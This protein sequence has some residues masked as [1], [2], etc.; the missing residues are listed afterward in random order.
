M[1]LVLSLLHRFQTLLMKHC[2][3]YILFALSIL[4]SCQK[5]VHKSQSN[6]QYPL[7]SETYSE[8]WKEVT[9][10]EKKGAGK[11]IIQKTGEILKKAKQD[12]NYHQVFKA[13]SY[14]SRYINQIEE[15]AHLKILTDFEKELN[16]AHFPLNLLLHSAIAELYSQYLSVNQWRYQNRTSIS[17]DRTE[18][19]R[20][21]SLDKIHRTINTHYK[22]S[23][24]LSEEASQFPISHLKP[25]LTETSDST[26]PTIYNSLYDFLAYRALNHFKA[27]PIVDLGISS[28]N[29]DDYYPF[30]TRKEFSQHN[31]QY[32]DS[33]DLQYLSFKL[34]QN[35]L[36][37]LQ[38]EPLKKQISFDLERLSHYHVTSNLPKKD[39]LFEA[40]LLHLKSEAEDNYEIRF[41]L[42][43]FYYEKGMEY[44]AHS[45]D[46]AKRWMTKKA[47]D[48]ISDLP[49]D[50]NDY[51]LAKCFDLLKEIEQESISFEMENIHV[52]NK[53][54]LLKLHFRNANEF[55]F[56]I[57]E[58][59]K[60]YEFKNKRHINHDNFMKQLCKMPALETWSKKVNL[61][62]DYQ[63]HSTELL[64][65]KLNIGKYYL[66]VSTQSNFNLTNGHLAYQEFQ[67]SQLSKLDRRRNNQIELYILDRES[68]KGMEGIQVDFYITK[69]QPNRSVELVSSHKSDK[70][71]F[72]SM[73]T[74]KHQRYSYKIYSGKDTLHSRHFYH[75]NDLKHQSRK[76]MHFFTDRAIYRPG[77][78]V[79]F[80]ALLYNSKGNE[81]KP[82]EKENV[83]I[84]LYDANGQ[85][86]DTIQLQSNTYGSVKGTFILPASG[87]NG[88]Y[89]IQGPSGSIQFAVEEYKRPTFKVSLDSLDGEARLNQNIHL[90]GSAKGFAGNPITQAKV[91]YRVIRKTEF[92]FKR[93]FYWD[94]YIPYHISQKEIAQGQ[95]ETGSDGIYQIEFNAL[96][97]NLNSSYQAI[98]N[99]QIIIDVIAINGET[100]S[101]MHNVRI[102]QRP[103]YISTNLK[104]GEVNIEDLRNL[105]INCKN[106]QGKRIDKKGSL[107]LVRLKDKSWATK[108]RFWQKPDI[109]SLDEVTYRSLRVSGRNEEVI[110]DYQINTT[111]FTAN[112]PLHLY[113]D[114]K[115]GQYELRISI[116]DQNGESIYYNEYFILNDFHSSQLPVKQFESIKALTTEGDPG[117]PARFLI[118]S[119]LV[120]LNVLYELEHG[121]KIIRQKWLKINDQQQLI[122]IP[123][124]EE[125]RGGFSVHFNAVHSNRSLHYLYDITVPF[126]NKNL[127]IK[128]LSHRDKLNPG[129][130]E[131]WSIKVEKN[132][133]STKESEVLVS[134]YDASLD[135]FRSQDWEWFPYQ[136]YK[137][138]LAWH[139]GTFGSIFSNEYGK[140]L[141]TKS[142]HR[143]VPQLNWFGFYL[144][145]GYRYFAKSNFAEPLML[146]DAVAVEDNESM[147][148]ANK[149]ESD[150]LADVAGVRKVNTV[151]N[152]TRKNFNETAFFY[153]Q[154]KT[155]NG[156]LNFEFKLPDALT[157]WKFRAFAHDQNFALGSFSK[158][159]VSQKEIMLFPNAPRF[160]REGDQ[161]LF[162]SSISN[163][164]DQWVEVMVRLEF[165]NPLTGRAIDL[166][167]DSSPTQR[168]QIKAKGN[169]SVDWKIKI[170]KGIEAIAYKISAES[171]NHIDSEERAIPVLP[172]RT[173][174][175]E[176]FPLSLRGKEIKEWKWEAL[177][178]AGNKQN[179]EHKSLS[180]EFSPNPVWY[181]IQALPYM[182]EQNGECTEQIFT[183]FFA[184]SIA[185]FIIQDQP[186]IKDI[187][188]QWEVNHS[189][190]LQSNLEKHQDLKAILIEETPWLQ[191]AKS[192]TEQ[193]KR[194]TLLFD[195][196][197][198]AMQKNNSLQKLKELQLSNGA[199]A[200]YTGMRPN[201]YLTQYLVSGFG[202]LHHLRIND[203]P[204]MIKNAIHYLDQEMIKDYQKLKERK[205][206]LKLNHLGYIHIYY[207]YARSFFPEVPLPSDRTAFDYYLNQ[208]QSYWTEQSNYM[209]GLI[210]LALHRSHPELST[211]KD[212]LFSLTDHA[213]L[214]EEMGMYWK[215][216]KGGYYWYNA[217]IE[218]HALLIEAFEEIGNDLS[219]IDELKIWLL[220][221]KQTQA[222]PSTRST[223]LACYALLQRGSNL[224]QQNEETH[225]QIGNQI[226]SSAEIQQEAG[227]GYFIKKWSA[228]EIDSNMGEIAAEN[229]NESIAW[230]ALHWQYYQN[231]DEVEAAGNS[232][233]KLHKQVFKVDLNSK[234]E[235]LTP[236]E[237]TP[238]QKGDKLRVRLKIE[239]DR[240]LE[241][242][243]LKDL[244]ASGLEPAQTLSGYQFQDGLGY[245]LSH[246]DA[247]TN[248]F[249]DYLKRGT[250]VLEYTLKANISGDFSNG[251]ST[252]QCFYAP[253]FN[254][255]SQGERLQID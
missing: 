254:S 154:Q 75:S 2:L 51:A 107:E 9:S 110:E 76:N 253:E 34:Y 146:L 231:L 102:S 47:H 195:Y 241:F 153:P 220:K 62:R 189:G 151:E 72:V 171:E 142:F 115:P 181:A 223:A 140:K 117:D 98:Y 172:N 158:T 208:A 190:A 49:Y 185:E 248:F 194:I 24:N 135:Q 78:H 124:K 131:K 251:F 101:L 57:L 67:V 41:E 138:R 4:L 133:E 210:A 184:N 150:D 137:S 228:S 44:Q 59:S 91:N 42:A 43:R 147:V 22:Q 216:N 96:A 10:L 217:K 81:F 113:K 74:E 7:I 19:I 30:S 156:E 100:Q 200:W 232:G 224:L 83:L 120:G 163:M 26:R 186:H 130:E 134:M 191:A 143:Y 20:E 165:Y 84:E 16:D 37:I 12:A 219:I 157:S 207:L 255:H 45:A 162:S 250:Y 187:F 252:L 132:R 218:S 23:L 122:S 214:D 1:N 56:R 245:Y 111:N 170:P 188:Q 32:P 145:G 246:K 89:R 65:P 148:H 152:Y 119:S 8:D 52:P 106:V 88:T 242:V 54:H 244:R 21:W 234:G 168:V 173:L 85:K 177:I 5:E 233:L 40:A 169:T 212:I 227:S 203:A 31:L 39:S 136:Q 197:Q 174:I 90:S 58:A 192:E 60:V 17:N 222:W 99:Y 108:T 61:D 160:F 29:P 15:D 209:K 112:E 215:E 182:T 221:Q 14:R 3:I 175:T 69:Y 27:S 79:H 28:F 149:K 159:I 239:C 66:L 35:L 161:L 139:K 167:D 11:Q 13:L 243:H 193:K 236:L 240:D 93:G 86:I 18:D 211:P 235:V 199:W 213:I 226:V 87:L 128:L 77:Q 73:M 141:S 71:G 179:L 92:H 80:K 36:Q 229:T 176:S 109:W 53:K 33:N 50:E 64:I 118:G 68:G 63:K 114:L 125:H 46:S 230:G 121:G 6:K 237:E 123:I 48:L 105:Q 249:F 144:G 25:I 205:A 129:S 166:I 94:Y 183:R 202:H 104:N 38:H 116:P 103:F 201:R 126:S 196:N 180:L 198:M 164:T 206:D 70:T 55:H 95:A 82:I 97:E 247:S 178:N 204:E 225:I 155:K 238:L 127:N